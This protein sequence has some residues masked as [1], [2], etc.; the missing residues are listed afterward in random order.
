MKQILFLVF[1]FMSLVGFGQVTVLNPSGGTAQIGNSTQNGVLT[2]GNDLQYGPAA[3]GAIP[4]SGD[5]FLGKNVYTKYLN[6]VDILKVYSSASNYNGVSALLLKDNGA[7]EFFGKQSTVAKDEVINLQTNL[8]FKIAENGNM[9]VGIEP[10]AKLHLAYGGQAM[11]FLTDGNTSGYRLD[12]GVNDDGINMTNNSAI[13]GFNWKNAT[14][15][16]M[17][18]QSNGYLGLGTPTPEYQLHVLSSVNNAGI[19]SETAT[20]GVGV[21]FLRLKSSNLSN[22]TLTSGFGSVDRFSI[23]DSK[24]GTNVERFIINNIGNVGI[25]TTSPT[26]NLHIDNNTSSKLR[27]S[28]INNSPAYY[29]EISNNYDSNNAFQIT[30][31]GFN[32]IKSSLDAYGF[33]EIGNQD[34]QKTNILT[35]KLIIP[36][37]NVGIGTASPQAKLHVESTTIENQY[38]IITPSVR[39]HSVNPSALNVGGVIELGGNTGNTNAPKYAFGFIGGLKETAAAENYA[40]YLSFR[41]VSGG[42]NSETMSANY[43]RM[44]ITS[45]GAVAINTTTV[46]ADYKLAINGNAIAN[47]IIVKQYPWADFVFKPEYELPPLSKVEDFIKKNGH[48]PE[49]PNEAEVKENGIDL[50]NMNAKLLQKVEELTLYLIEMKKE[51]EMLKKQN[52]E[53][54]KRLENVEKH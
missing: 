13:R 16:L 29:S 27:L 42:H 30:N 48:L 12:I 10:A 3:I 28:S 40:G 14:G 5:L 19:I 22:F 36:N 23:I 32:I 31:H 45:T 2:L 7:L 53:I 21:P 47:K 44:R 26:A 52:I 25:G 4:S 17:T 24:N 46:P 54:L 1:T 51:N 11:R 50:G 43:E 37:G 15:T 33:I 39:V 9:G 8:R 18:L 20:P 41:T 38:G 6:S 49:I 34:N 35:Q